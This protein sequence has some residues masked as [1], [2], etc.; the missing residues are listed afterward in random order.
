[1]IPN[2]SKLEAFPNNKRKIDDA[3][4]KTIIYNH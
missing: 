3:N 1:M 4:A 2:S